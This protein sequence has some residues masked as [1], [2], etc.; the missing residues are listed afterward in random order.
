MPLFEINSISI[1]KHKYIV[2]A[3][4][5]EKAISSIGNEGLEELE[6]KHIAENLLDIRTINKKEFNE[7][8]ENSRKEVFSNSHLK[9]KIIYQA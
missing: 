5:R 4:S 3:D 1:F 2:K 6:Q 9:E 8:I 7:I